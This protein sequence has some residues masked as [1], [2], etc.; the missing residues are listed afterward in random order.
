LTNVH[1]LELLEQLDVDEISAPAPFANAGESPPS[2]LSL[3]R[4]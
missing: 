3:S 2:A 1:F 4:H